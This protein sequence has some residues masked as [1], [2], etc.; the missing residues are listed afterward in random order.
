MNP[1]Y[2]W[3]T[4]GTCPSR[5][6]MDIMAAPITEPSVFLQEIQ[7][8]LS[9]SNHTVCIGGELK[10]SSEGKPA[11]NF[12]YEKDEDLNKNVIENYLQLFRLHK[13]IYNWPIFVTTI[14]RSWRTYSWLITKEGGI[15]R[16]DQEYRRRKDDETDPIWYHGFPFGEDYYDVEDE[17]LRLFLSYN[18]I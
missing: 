18:C 1:E 2:T 6:Y 7:K 15:I 10:T 9:L 13:E 8:I 14:P 17:E 11:S 5:N 16:K 12:R 3:V 4:A